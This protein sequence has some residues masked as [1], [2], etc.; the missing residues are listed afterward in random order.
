MNEMERADA[1]PLMW[2]LLAAGHL[3]DAQLNDALEAH[4]LSVAKFGV[5]DQLVLAGEPM[6]LR[7]L[8]ERLSCVKSN[9]TQL[10]DRLEAEKLVKRVPDPADRRSIRAQITEAGRSRHEAGQ[11]ALGEAGDALVQRFS[12]AERAALSGLLGRLSAAE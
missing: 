10:V 9:V 4:G 8:A 1:Q 6:P 12:G 11:S 5:L 3:I 2:G 7:V